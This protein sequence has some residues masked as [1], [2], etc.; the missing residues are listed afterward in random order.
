MLKHGCHVNIG[1]VELA[2]V[3]L[4]C[5]RVIGYLNLRREEMGGFTFLSTLPSCSFKI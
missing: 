2:A 3:T 1:T 4:K 5:F